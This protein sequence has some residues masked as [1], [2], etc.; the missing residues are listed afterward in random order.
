MAPETLPLN[1][2]NAVIRVCLNCGNIWRSRTD[3]ARPQCYKCRRTRSREATPEEIEAYETGI[4]NVHLLNP[5]QEDP[6][7]PTPEDFAGIPDDQMLDPTPGAEAPTPE[8]PPAS[9]G[10][11]PPA[12]IAIGAV[13]LIGA[14]A[15]VYF[16]YVRPKNADLQSQEQGTVTA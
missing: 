9:G 2:E 6:E 3:I 15:G 7:I 10:G 8:A 14:I 12:A 5:Q 1:G 13:L 11:I 16:L 4:T